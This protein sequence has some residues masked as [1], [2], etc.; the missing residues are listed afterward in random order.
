MEKNQNPRLQNFL[1]PGEFSPLKAVWLAWPSDENLWEENFKGAQ[2]SVLALAS[3]VQS[4]KAKVNLICANESREREAKKKFLEK[5]IDAT[6]FVIPYGDIWLRDTAPIFVKNSR[7]EL[8]SICFQFN[9]WGKKYILKGDQELSLA[10]AKIAGY[11]IYQS[12]FIFEGGSLEVNGQGLGI[13]TKECVLNPNRNP[14]IKK[15]DIENNLNFFLGVK[16]LIW[17]KNGLKNDHTDGHVDNL[18]RFITPEILLCMEP[19]NMEDPNY[20]VLMEIQETLREKTNL[21][22]KKFKTLTLPS[23]GEVFDQ[24]D[25]LMAASYLN[26]LIINQ[27][28]AVPQFQRPNDQKVLDVFKKILPDKT[29]IGI[30]CLDLLTGGGGLHCISQPVPS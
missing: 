28:V 20:D 21:L 4:G 8:C 16:N 26:F 29:I 9:G 11:P 17:L 18:V 24:K 13:T 1:Q 27:C 23:P 6:F 30:D 22:G 3:A 12:D 14:D 15:N 19:T 10:I 2:N 7:N 5:D 25:N